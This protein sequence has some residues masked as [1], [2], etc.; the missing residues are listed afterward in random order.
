MVNIKLGDNRYYQVHNYW[1]TYYLKGPVTYYADRQKWWRS[2]YGNRDTADMVDVLMADVDEKNSK[3]VM[4]Y[5][6]GQ[7]LNDTRM[8]INFGELAKQKGFAPTNCSYNVGKDQNVKILYRDFKTN[9][10]I[11]KDSGSK[12]MGAAK[13]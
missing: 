7:L 1:N 4:L 11:L 3:I 5:Q 10:L 9:D 12:D 13:E 2:G 8:F 6:P